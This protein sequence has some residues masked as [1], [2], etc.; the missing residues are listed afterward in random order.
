MPRGR[1]ST[2]AITVQARAITTCMMYLQ[3][4]RHADSSTSSSYC[5]REGLR[6]V[7][8]VCC[9]TATSCRQQSIIL[10]LCKGR[11]AYYY[12][13]DVPT[14]TTSCRQQHTI[15]LLCKGR[16]A[17]YDV[18]A[19]PTATTS[20]T[21]YSTILLLC[22][23]RATWRTACYVLLRHEQRTCY[24]YVDAVLQLSR[25]CTTYRHRLLRR[26]RAACMATYVECYPLPLTG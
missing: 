24:H 9:P 18:H 11:A 5:V 14:A 20:C 22:K 23:G 13:H 7:L 6:A 3:L 25:A 15:L 10:L 19:V 4:L 2:T 12:V 21:R 16:A 8:R 1:T 17:Y 26:R